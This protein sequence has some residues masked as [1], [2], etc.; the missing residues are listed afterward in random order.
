MEHGAQ[1]DASALDRNSP[2]KRITYRA[3]LQPPVLPSPAIPP[4]PAIPA[5]VVPHGPTWKSDHDI[6]MAALKS[7]HARDM[8]A[9]T[10]PARPCPS[11]PVP[12][13]LHVAPS[14]RLRLRL[15]LFPADPSCVSSNAPK[16]PLL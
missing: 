11:L 4:P 9:C 5:S 12:A 1:V 16:S 15:R 10:V 7:P 8:R 14:V 13:R 6:E 2:A 3:P